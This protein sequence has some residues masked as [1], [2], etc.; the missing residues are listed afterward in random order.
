MRNQAL[1]LLIMSA[2][3]ATGAPGQQKS[4]NVVMQPAAT[5]QA[6]DVR[7]VPMPT[8]GLSEPVPGSIN[9]TVPTGFVSRV[10]QFTDIRMG[11]PTSP[12]L[13]VPGSFT[14]NAGVTGSISTGQTTSTTDLGILDRSE[15]GNSPRP[16]G[17][18]SGTNVANPDGTSIEASSAVSMVIQ[19][20]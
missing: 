20:R 6:T 2:V 7:I 14:S 4:G 1:A 10:R 11:S 18:R 17:S 15:S 13:P 12:L 3:A 16:A 8:T 19:T 5:R 9:F